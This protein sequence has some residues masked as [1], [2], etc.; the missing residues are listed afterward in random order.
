MSVPPLTNLTFISGLGGSTGAKKFINTTDKYWVVKRSEKGH[1]GSEQVEIEFAANEIYEAVGI[2]VPSHALMKDNNSNPVLVLE[3]IDGKLLSEA[4]AEEYEKAKEELKQGFVMDA[5]L[6]NWDVIG[7]GKD[8]ILLPADGSPAVRIDNG[9]TLI[10]RAQGGRKK[11]TADVTEIN[12]LR[13]ISIPSYA[14]ILF[15]DLTDEEIQK[16]IDTLI[17]PNYEL[18]LSKTPEALRPVM[19]ARMDSLIERFHVANNHS[20]GKRN[21]SHKRSI[22]TTV[23]KRIYKKRTIKRNYRRYNK[24]KN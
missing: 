7:L 6:A 16:Q 1:G 23:R 19:K 9:G 2:P 3:Y 24:N 12:T 22:H 11:F 21:K 13:N 8:N 14:P 5:L 15:G 4:T 20:G 17:K 18:I 10:F